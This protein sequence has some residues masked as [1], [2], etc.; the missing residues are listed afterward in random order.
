MAVSAAAQSTGT[1]N[2]NTGSP[3][4]PKKTAA[5]GQQKSTASPASAKS[6]S[7]GKTGPGTAAATTPSKTSPGT[8]AATPVQTGKSTASQPAKSGQATSKTGPTSKNAPATTKTAP[9][10]KTGAAASTSAKSKT[11][12][13]TKTGPAPVTAGKS[14]AQKKSPFTTNLAPPKSGKKTAGP[15]TAKKKSVGGAPV[16]G[17]KKSTKPAGKKP[18]EKKPVVAGTPSAPASHKT[19]HAAGKRDPFVSPIRVTSGGPVPPSNCAS[20]KRCLF[21]PE[22]IVQGTV[23]DLNGKMLAVVVNRARHTYF[24]RESDQVFNGSVQRITTDSV[25]FREYVTDNMGRESAHEVVKRVGGGPS[26]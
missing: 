7:T 5:Q 9:A 22:L 13:A 6:T 10:T 11:G 20:G 26:T 19:F 21:I 1:N 16:A 18:V 24:L 12:P 3:A 4:P 15:T 23:R 25:V 14:G 2:Q 17:K 8:R